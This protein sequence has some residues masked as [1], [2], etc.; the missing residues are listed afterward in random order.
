[1][2]VNRLL[3]Y[4]RDREEN[5]RA[6]GCDDGQ[7]ELVLGQGFYLRCRLGVYPLPAMYIDA[8]KGRD[9]CA[10]T[11]F[12]RRAVTPDYRIWQRLLIDMV[13][14]PQ[15]RFVAFTSIQSTIS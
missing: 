2:C 12:F 3:L 10:G 11:I 1:M 14:Y 4:H 15:E 7:Q 9:E 13:A 8:V 6:P 5:F